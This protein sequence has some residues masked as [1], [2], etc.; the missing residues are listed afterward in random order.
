MAWRSASNTIHAATFIVHTG[1]PLVHTKCRCTS[2]RE[3]VGDACQ[4]VVLLSMQRLSPLCAFPN[5]ACSSVPRTPACASCRCCRCPPH[6]SVYY[7]SRL[8]PCAMS[9]YDTASAQ[10]HNYLFRQH[11][12]VD[13]SLSSDWSRYCASGSFYRSSHPPAYH[14][15]Q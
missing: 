8:T 14:A 2:Y 12:S 5:L 1:I 4:I 6:H 3:V 10:R 13:K 11:S 9:S 15:S 7:H